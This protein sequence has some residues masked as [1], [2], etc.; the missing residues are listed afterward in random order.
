MTFKKITAMYMLLW[1]TIY[2]FRINI[3]GC[4]SHLRFYSRGYCVAYY[5]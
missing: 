1:K 5:S 3:L 2:V 4:C